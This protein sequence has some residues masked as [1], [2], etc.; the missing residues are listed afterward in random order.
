MPGRAFPA[1]Q[2][3]TEF[4][5]SISVPF[6]FLTT[7]S[8]SAAVFNSFAP[9]AAISPRI[10]AISISGYGISTPSFPLSAFRFPLSAL[11]S[12][13]PAFRFPH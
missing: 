1:A 6:V 10:G 11:R 5:T 12:P 3:H 4:T 13:L 8:T 9:I 7:S 2:P